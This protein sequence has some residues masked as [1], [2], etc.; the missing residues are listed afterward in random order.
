MRTA[1]GTVA[2]RDSLALF[3]EEV[4]KLYASVEETVDSALQHPSQKLN[5]GMS[6]LE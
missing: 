3:A 4:M 1:K 6:L 2:R 5:H